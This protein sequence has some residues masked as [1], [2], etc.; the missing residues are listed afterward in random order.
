MEQVKLTVTLNRG[1]ARCDEMAQRFTVWL[2]HPFLL[3][4][5][6]LFSITAQT[7]SQLQ[8]SICMLMR[9]KEPSCAPP[10]LL[11]PPPSIATA[12]NQYT[13]KWADMNV[14]ASSP[15]R[16]SV[17]TGAFLVCLHVGLYERVRSKRDVPLWSHTLVYLLQECVHFG[18]CRLLPVPTVLP[19]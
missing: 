2:L 12:L 19:S 10:P 18:H 3:P 7:P 9:E 1:I 5:F 6:H 11:E 16:V 15:Q 13:L 17:S 14:G 8:K 4:S